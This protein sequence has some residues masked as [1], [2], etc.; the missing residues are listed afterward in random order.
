MQFHLP[1]QK[2]LEYPEDGLVIIF[3]LFKYELTPL[4]HKTY[5]VHQ[6][7]ALHHVNTP[8]LRDQ[9]N[10]NGRSLVF[11]SW[12]NAIPSSIRYTSAKRL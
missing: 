8:E 12:E 4:S 9:T 5:R 6:L 7:S 1:E 3:V 2:Y 11:S 10:W